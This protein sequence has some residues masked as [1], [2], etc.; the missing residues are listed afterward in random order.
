[1]ARNVLPARVSAWWD[2]LSAIQSSGL[3]DASWYR[4]QSRAA[5]LS[6][7]PLIHYLLFGWK[8]GLNPSNRFDT[9]FYIERYRDVKQ[10]DANPLMHY[11]LHG[12][13]EGRLTTQ[14]G[15]IVRTSLHPEFHPLPIFGVPGTPGSRLTLMLDDN[16]PRLIGIGYRAVLGMASHLAHHHSLSLRVLIRSNTIS[17]GDVSAQLNDV[18]PSA[19]PELTITR[20]SPGPCDDVD[21]IDDELWWTTSAS[22]LASIQPFVPPTHATWV[23][24]ADE[25]NRSASGEYRLQVAAALHDSTVQ[26]I[27][28]G[29]KL[30]AQLSPAGPL[31]VIT[32]LPPVSEL[33]AAQSSSRGIT[34]I[35]ERENGESLVARSIELIEYG[36]TH[37]VIVPTEQTISFLGLDTDPVTLSGSVEVTQFSNADPESWENTLSSASHV[38]VL[39]AGTEEPWLARELSSLGYRVVAPDPLDSRDIATLA[40]SLEKGAK[41]AK[42]KTVTWKSALSHLGKQ[43]F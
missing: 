13:E 12:R 3:F 15:A 37:G 18:L 43:G 34:V 39:G 16:T 31:K 35:V 24:T 5:A 33:P 19:R 27:V 36:L 2:L 28:L 11:V 1:M 41:A 9:R 20:R 26:T 4:R 14:T 22:A 10:S 23:V 25:G 6:P 42:G 21:T 32:A 7:S 40:A 38:V 30:K 17:S 29:E 8:H